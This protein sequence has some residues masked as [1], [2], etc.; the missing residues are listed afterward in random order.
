MP[1]DNEQEPNFNNIHERQKNLIRALF[2]LCGIYIGI[3]QDVLREEFNDIHRVYMGDPNWIIDNGSWATVKN[4]LEDRRILQINYILNNHFERIALFSL[5]PGIFEVPHLDDL[6]PILQPYFLLSEDILHR[7]RFQRKRRLTTIFQIL[8]ALRT[9]ILDLNP[10]PIFESETIDIA[11]RPFL[12]AIFNWIQQDL[13]PSTTFPFD[14]FGE[15]VFFINSDRIACDYWNQ[16]I[17]ELLS[18]GT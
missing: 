16:L 6:F 9:Q 4:S 18:N 13:P 15:F 1:P 5:N 14:D 3:Q 11:L 8:L 10:S 7:E 17:E 12:L 2:G